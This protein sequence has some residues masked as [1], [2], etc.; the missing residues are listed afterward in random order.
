MNWP[1]HIGLDETLEILPSISAFTENFLGGS[2][3]AP[4]DRTITPCPA[5]SILLSEDPGSTRRHPV[6]LPAD[7]YPERATAVAIEQERLRM[8]REIHDVSGQHLISMLFQLIA[9][10]R[11]QTDPSLLSSLAA[12]R[13]ALTHFS[14]DLHEIAKGGTPGVPRSAELVG[15][16]SA[17][18]ANW[19]TQSGIDVRFRHSGLDPGLLDDLAAEAIYRVVQE[20]L[21]NIAK[22]AAAATAVTVELHVRTERLAL[23]VED[24]GAGPVEQS[25]RGQR[26]EGCGITGMRQ[27]IK[28]LGGTFSAGARR[29]VSGMRLAATIPLYRIPVPC[30]E[31]ADT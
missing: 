31:G 7:D 11:T 26:R 13:C 12:L 15:A 14:E 9:I 19:G 27:R 10:E 5:A 1:P 4:A 24:N 21:T 18:T 17:L 29:G 6:L 30:L 20:G 22:H 16:I 25:Q 28:E 8:A 3:P 2:L 23:T